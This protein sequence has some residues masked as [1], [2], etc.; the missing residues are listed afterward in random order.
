MSTTIAVIS[1]TIGSPVIGV[2]DKVLAAIGNRDFIVITIF[3]AVGILMAI[4]LA[5][6]LG[7]LGDPSASLFQVS[8]ASQIK[9]A[10]NSPGLASA[11]PGKGNADR[12]DVTGAVTLQ[13][14]VPD[15]DRV[16]LGDDQPLMATGL[17]LNGPPK[18]ISAKEI[19]G[20][21]EIPGF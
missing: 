19:L 21:L 7:P 20:N 10:Q 6:Y 3:S 13:R 4:L 9:V 5:V 15:A 14:S 2:Q 12:T 11:S 1:P 17:D 8:V 16:E 18:R